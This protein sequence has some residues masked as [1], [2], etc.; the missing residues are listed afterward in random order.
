MPEVFLIFNRKAEYDLFR[1][2]KAYILETI[3]A[4]DLCLDV[5]YTR[6]LENDKEQENM[7]LYLF[8]IDCGVFFKAYSLV[9]HPGKMLGL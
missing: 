6:F 8:C 4:G 1:F 7:I 3:E 5:F 9:D 2:F